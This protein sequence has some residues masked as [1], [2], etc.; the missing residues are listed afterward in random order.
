V[1]RRPAKYA[2]VLAKM[3]RLVSYGVDAFA[4]GERGV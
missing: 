1:R 2:R 4:S 3:F